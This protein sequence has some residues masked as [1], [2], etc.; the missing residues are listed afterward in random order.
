MF[1]S[2]RKKGK[3]TSSKRYGNPLKILEQLFFSLLMLG[4]Q[5]EFPWNDDYVLLILCPIGRP[6]SLH[7]R[8]GK[9]RVQVVGSDSY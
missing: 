6:C 2:E 7:S 8:S 9:S 5:T 1:D 3:R 4:I